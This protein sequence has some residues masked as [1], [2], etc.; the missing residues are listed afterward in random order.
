LLC[1]LTNPRSTTGLGYRHPGTCR[2]HKTSNKD[3]SGSK[4][5]GAVNSLVT[6]PAERG[7]DSGRRGGSGGGPAGEEAAGGQGR[8]DPPCGGGHGEFIAARN[9]SNRLTLSN[10]RPVLQARPQLV[11]ARN[12]GGLV[13]RI[14]DPPGL[15]N[16]PGCWT[17]KANFMRPSY[18]I[19]CIRLSFLY[20][21]HVFGINLK[22][23]VT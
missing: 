2:A 19:K 8:G 9:E 20:N 16:R 13:Y 23:Y 21:T 6:W 22:I 12:N 1:S 5:P 4:N 17:W 15:V 3:S 18:Y 11:G 7:G 14:S 10:A